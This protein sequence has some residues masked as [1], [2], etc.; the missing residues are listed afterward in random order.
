VNWSGTSRATRTW[1]VYFSTQRLPVTIQPAISA[2]S[3]L[4]STRALS[5]ARTRKRVRFR[6]SLDLPFGS[7]L[8]KIYLT[9]RHGCRDEGGELFPAKAS[10][11]SFQPAR[12][13]QISVAAVRIQI[14]L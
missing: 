13:G 12:P 9:L 2:S 4:P 14:S 8:P 7:P 3:L 1:P 6:E 10:P 5:I 11:L